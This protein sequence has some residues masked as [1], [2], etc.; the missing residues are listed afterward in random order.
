[1]VPGSSAASRQESKVGRTVSAGSVCAALLR[2]APVPTA[3]G[4]T[5]VTVASTTPRA[6]RAVMRAPG[7]S[8]AASVITR[9]FSSVT[10][11]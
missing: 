3:P 7:A 1:M 10:M 8:P 11:A 5:A 9:E 2:V 4:V 6:T